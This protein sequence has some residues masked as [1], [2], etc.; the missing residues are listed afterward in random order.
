MTLKNILLILISL[1]LIIGCSD[2]AASKQEKNNFEQLVRN[3]E[4]CQT[5]YE[6]EYNDKPIIDVKNGTNRPNLAG[7]ISDYLKKNCYD[8]YAGNWDKSNVKRTYAIIDSATLTK[9][10]SLIDELRNTLGLY[11]SIITDLK[12]CKSCNIDYD[13]TLV[14][15]NDYK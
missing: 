9:K 13:I 1:F 6:I 12:T 8:A 5:N 15:G 7:Q 14:I 4:R 2:K 3:Y 10:I 11:F